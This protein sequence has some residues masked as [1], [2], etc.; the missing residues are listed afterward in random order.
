M[1]RLLNKYRKEVI[2]S[3]MTEFG[4]KNIMAVPKIEKVVI[5]IG[6]GKVGTEPRFKD[7]IEKDIALITGQKPAFRKARKSI[8]GFKIRQGMIVGFKATLRGKRMYDFLDRFISVALPRSRDFRGID[9]KSFDGKG[10]LNIGVREQIIFPEISYESSKDI[11]PFQ[12]TATTTAKTKEEGIEL[13]RLLGFPIK[14][15]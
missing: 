1:P 4:Y 5:N 11:F 15:G 13:L 7:R 12:I 6:A 9:V 14:G 2:P 10:S 3:M 8:S